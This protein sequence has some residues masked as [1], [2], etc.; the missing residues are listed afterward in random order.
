MQWREHLFTFGA[1]LVRLEGD[2]HLNREL[3]CE[4]VT[5][6]PGTDVDSNIDIDWYRL[7][8]QYEFGWDMDDKGSRFSLAPGLQAVVFEPNDEPL[9]A[10]IRLNVGA[11]MQ[12]L[13][14]Q[15]AFQGRSPKEAYFVRCGSNTT[16]QDD[17]NRG[18][19][20]NSM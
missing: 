10:E 6:A 19:V 7:G 11:F 2:A 5:Y 3:I 14:R 15:G 12:G 8:Y 17:I 16:T 18:I 20:N 1:R 4:E 9:W 13:F